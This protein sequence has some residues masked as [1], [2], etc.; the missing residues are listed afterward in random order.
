[1][2]AASGACTVQ[3]T[4]RT[5]GYA[6]SPNLVAI[7]SGVY[8]VENHSQ[9][10]FYSDG[11]YWMAGNGGWYRS[12]Y[13]DRGWGYVDYG[14]VPQRVIRIRQPRSYVHYRARPGMNVRKAS[15]IDHRRQGAPARQATPVH[16]SNTRVPAVRGRA[17]APAHRTVPSARARP[18]ARPVAR[19]AARP[20]ARQ[21]PAARP[22]RKERAPAPR[23]AK[24]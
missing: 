13:Y 23:R 8:V 24:P 7:G 10:V 1:M 2:L 4:T 3:G 12:S 17:P 11:Y 16:R 21:Q 14:Y 20:P 15:T 5:T 22:T 9:S 18:A 19:P 6:S